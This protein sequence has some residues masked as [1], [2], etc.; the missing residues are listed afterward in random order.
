MHARR[1]TDQLR[2]CRLFDAEAANTP[3]R[4]SLRGVVRGPDGGAG[5]VEN[6]VRIERVNGQRAHP[7]AEG[8]GLKNADPRGDGIVVAGVGAEGG[9]SGAAV[10]GAIE[11]VV[12]TPVVQCR[13]HD[14]AGILRVSRNGAVAALI[15]QRRSDVGPNI[16]G[17]VELP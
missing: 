12:R 10:G 14:G 15:S 17:G 1:R 16:A 2:Y 5:P 7:P 13:N 8:A 4:G 3:V 11:V 6:M 9:P